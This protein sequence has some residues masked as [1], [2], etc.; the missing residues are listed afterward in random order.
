VVSALPVMVLYL[1]FQRHLT[2]GLTLGALK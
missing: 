1:V 2:G